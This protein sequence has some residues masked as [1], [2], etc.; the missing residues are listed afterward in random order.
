MTQPARKP[1]LRTRQNPAGN[2]I[3]FTAQLFG[4]KSREAALK[5]A[6]DVGITYGNRARDSPKSGKKSL[7]KEKGKSPETDWE[8]ERA[9][10]TKAYLD[11]RTLI[12]EWKE[13]YAPK[14]PEEEWDGHF[15]TALRELSIVEYY[16]E[17]LLFGDEEDKKCSSR[18]KEPMLSDSITVRT[19][20]R[21]CRRKSTGCWLQKSDSRKFDKQ[22]RI[23]I[24]INM[25]IMNKW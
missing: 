11:Y 23:W 19:Q 25:E 24:P 16:L 8:T 17:I 3:D 13:C 21:R 7:V 12:L 15:V 5:L 2:V 18:K 9:R 10:L 22:R 6:D 20:E 1:A 4:L 14:T